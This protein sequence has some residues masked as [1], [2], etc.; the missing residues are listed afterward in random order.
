MHREE[1][2]SRAHILLAGTESS[3]NTDP[4]FELLRRSS[5]AAASALNGLSSIDVETLRV[6]VAVFMAGAQAQGCGES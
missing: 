1:G 4:L 3:G 6:L 5:P 2:T